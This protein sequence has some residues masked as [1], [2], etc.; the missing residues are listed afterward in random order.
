MWKCGIRNIR[1]VHVGIT[2]GSLMPSRCRGLHDEEDD[3][4]EEPLCR[5]DCES[6][7]TAEGSGR[8]LDGRA[9]SR[10][11]INQ[12]KYPPQSSLALTES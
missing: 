2:G 12:G 7:R 1:T 6:D 5:I 8:R 3:G 10:K 4:A 9:N 11:R